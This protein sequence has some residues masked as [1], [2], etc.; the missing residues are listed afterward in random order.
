[1]I[2]NNMKPTIVM[3]SHTD[4][5][6]V[7]KPF[8][9]QTAKWMNDYK[10]VIM[11]NKKDDEIPSDYSIITY[12]DTK[13]YRHRL[14]ECLEQIED[15]LIMFHHEDMFLYDKPNL[16]KIEEYCDFLM[17]SNKS[18]IKMIKGGYEDGVLESGFDSLKHI[19]K[20][21]RYIFAIQPTIWKT[22]DFLK[23]VSNSEGDSIWQFENA[24]Q[25]VCRRL[26]IMGYYVDDKG[27]RR[28]R[29]HW[30]SKTYPYVATA[31]VKGCWNVREYPHE[32]Q[33]IFE[34]YDVDLKK[35]KFNI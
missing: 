29:L 3:Y 21:F 34:E 35:R 12:D 20:S 28:G 8:F 5:K 23:L 32:L 2:Y 14:I 1:M 19:D 22:K 31:V 7:W 24:A 15:E 26:N 17:K 30:D 9:G 10:K 6:D 13:I 27:K 16:E 33:S 4:V 18:F 25:G 11:V